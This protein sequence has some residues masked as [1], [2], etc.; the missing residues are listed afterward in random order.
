MNK[1]QKEYLLKLTKS[2]LNI[3]F[4]VFLYAASLSVV[5]GLI[6]LQSYIP[7]VQII[8]CAC[9]SLLVI[10]L[11]LYTVLCYIHRL[12]TVITNFYL[13][14][15]LPE[16]EYNRYKYYL[17]IAC[18]ELVLSYDHYHDDTAMQYIKKF[19]YIKYYCALK[20]SQKL[21]KGS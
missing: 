21:K 2:F 3:L 7:I 5:T 13:M 14:G 6:V 4:I 20:K 10:F 11:I 8:L 16:N 12:Y 19:H 9:S 1:L 17:T 15:K 18:I